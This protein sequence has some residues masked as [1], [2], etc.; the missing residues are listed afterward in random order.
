M[1]ENVEL[2]PTQSKRRV[3]RRKTLYKSKTKKRHAH[4]IDGRYIF[5]VFSYGGGEYALLQW[6]SRAI[7]EN[8]SCLEC[9]T[10]QICASGLVR[11]IKNGGFGNNVFEA[12]LA[13]LEALTFALHR[14]TLSRR[15][16][17]LVHD[18]AAG[19]RA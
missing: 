2:R 12:N 5:I 6:S 18:D 19:G 16:A 10:E 7:R 17:I 8:G 3:V 11:P 1:S 4:L 9:L 13:E 15:P 14:A